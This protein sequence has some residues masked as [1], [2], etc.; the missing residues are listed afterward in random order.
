MGYISSF[1]INPFPWSQLEIMPGFT[2][3][4]SFLQS[5]IILTV[6]VPKYLQWCGWGIYSSGIWCCIMGIWLLTIQEIAVTSKCQEPNPEKQHHTP[7]G[8]IPYPQSCRHSG[9]ECHEPNA[10]WHRIMLQKKRYPPQEH[11]FMNAANISIRQH[12]NYKT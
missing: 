3:R 2:C 7:T 1:I 6:R 12:F 11:G 10:L 5:D 9:L 8:Q 4:G